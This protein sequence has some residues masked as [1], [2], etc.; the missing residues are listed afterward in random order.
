MRYIALACDYDGTLAHDGRVN[1]AT[2]A[3]LE[4]LKASGRRLILVTG[5]QVDD[6]Q[7]VFPEFQVFERIVAENGAVLVDPAAREQRTLAEPPSMAFIERLRDRGVSPFDVGHVIVATWRPNEIEVLTAIR[8]LGLEHQ[9]IFN[10][11][12]VMVLPPGVNKATGLAA[13]LDELRL[14]PHNVVAVGDAEND[15]AL[16]QACEC[17]VAVANAVPMLKERADLVT[18][19][20]R[21]EGVTQLIDRLIASDLADLSRALARHE[22]LLGRDSGG[23]DVRLSPYG[24]NVLLAGPSGVGKSTLTNGLLERLSDRGYQFCLVDPEGDHE[25]FRPAVVL[26]TAQKAPEPAEVMAVL[27]VPAQNAIVNL[28]GVAL[29]E[30]PRAFDQLVARLQELR[31]L[32]ARPHWL[33]LD[34]VHH[35]LPATWRPASGTI[36]SR[37]HNLL[38]VTVDPGLVAP[39]ALQSVDTLLLKGPDPSAL[40]DRFVQATGEAA[41]PG[42]LPA[43]TPDEALLWRRGNR[44][45]DR[46]TVEPPRAAHRRHR[47]KYAEGE[48]IE[49]ERFTFRGPRGQLNLRAENLRVFVKMAEGVD[50]ETWLHHLRLGHYSQWFRRAIKD[51][52]LA[53]EAEAVERA[54]L[55]AAESRARIREAVERRYAV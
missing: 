29:E 31:A 50:E 32:A 38:M 33:V 13:A 5:R 41:A 49:E 17:G 24:H 44:Q 7:R 47:R 54:E 37:P 25:A 4:R 1:Q 53:A 2:R 27:E 42:R 9:V 30:R 51:D 21:G 45:L 14:S 55:P 20:P 10:K 43:L 46:F 6:L 8:D 23:A 35:L 48:L 28:T 40:V 52:T 34:E 18:E 3:A 26:G 11:D 12:A 39:A 15:H 36:P 16:L 19:A 22:V